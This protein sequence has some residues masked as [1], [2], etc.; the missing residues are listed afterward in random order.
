[1][2]SIM[3]QERQTQERE[4]ADENQASNSE[5]KFSWNRSFC[6]MG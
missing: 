2:D 5:M 4:N 6:E 1:M 3:E